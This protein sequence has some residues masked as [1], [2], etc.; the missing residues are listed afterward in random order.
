MDEKDKD[1][2]QSPPFKK[3]NVMWLAGFAAAMFLSL[4]IIVYMLMGMGLEPLKVK[5]IR[6]QRTITVETTQHDL[7]RREV[8]SG[9]D[10]DVA[11]VPPEPGEG[12]VV[13]VSDPEY[14]VTVSDG[15]FSWDV[16]VDKDQF[17]SAQPGSTFSYKR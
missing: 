1:K 7:I 14:T 8:L 13:N 9:T 5:N 3:G 15:R 2:M 10:H 17:E 12:Q 16:T 4:G 11:V 6:W